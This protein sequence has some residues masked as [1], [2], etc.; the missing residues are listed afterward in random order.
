MLQLQ[1]LENRGI[2]RIFTREALPPGTLWQE[3]T[4]IEISNTAAAILL[5]SPDYLA[6][7]DLMEDQL[8]RLLARAQEEDG[9]AILPL[10]VRPSL[11]SDLPYIYRFKPFKPY[12]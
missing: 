12:S 9:T 8:P 2:V 10:L 4:E 11:F 1:V 3:E 7:K 5:V 6:S